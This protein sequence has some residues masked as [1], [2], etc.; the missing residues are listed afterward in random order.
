MPEE[1]T[2]TK[3]ALETLNAFYREM[4]RIASSWGAL[5]FLIDQTIWKLAG[6]DDK[7]GACLTAQIIAIHGRS[8]ALVS[9]MNLRGIDAELI[10]E[11]NRFTGKAAEPAQHR[12]RI[13]HSPLMLDETM[14]KVMKFSIKADR[15]LEFDSSIVDFDYAAKTLNQISDHLVEFDKLK[16]AILAAY[17]PSPDKSLK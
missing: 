16:S 8:R 10:K 3:D 4:G 2:P 17:V 5:E 13:V 6:L 12:N 9:L 1:L 11:V 7:P 15:Q 14:S